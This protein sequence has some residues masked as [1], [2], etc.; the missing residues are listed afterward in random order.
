KELDEAVDRNLEDYEHLHQ[1]RILGKRLRYAMEVFADCFAAAFRE[2]LYPAVE[3]MQEILGNA[4]DSYVAC[5]RLEAVATQWQAPVAPRWGGGG[6]ERVAEW[7]AT[8]G[9]TVPGLVGAL[10]SIRWR[11]RLLRSAQESQRPS[12]GGGRAHSCSIPVGRVAASRLA[13]L[14]TSYG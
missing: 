2:Q 1:V 5:G 13:G 14:P 7:A 12:G 9:G 10:V 4:N 6:A 3:E 11:G 8:G